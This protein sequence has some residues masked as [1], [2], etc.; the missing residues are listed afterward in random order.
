MINRILFVV[1]VFGR[2]VCDI[3]WR[4]L[5]KFDDKHLECLGAIVHLDVVLIKH[6]DQRWED[7]V[8]IY[9][10]DPDLFRKIDETVKKLLA[11]GP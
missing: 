10:A 7:A 3:V 2:G 8:R 11:L 9:H 4:Y 6:R 5:E 1:P